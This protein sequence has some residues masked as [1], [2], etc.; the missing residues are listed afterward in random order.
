[1]HDFIH[2]S[3]KSLLVVESVPQTRDRI[4]E[5][6]DA[7]DIQVTTSQL[8]EYWRRRRGDHHL[9]PRPLLARRE[10]PPRVA[11]RPDGCETPGKSAGVL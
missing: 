1:M 8:I 4:L 2:R 10:Q 11:A 7:S 5:A 9:Q 3:M 6:I